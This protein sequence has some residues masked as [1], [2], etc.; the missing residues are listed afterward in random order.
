[1]LKRRRIGA[2]LLTAL[3]TILAPIAGSA[4]APNRH[5]T[6]RV[7]QGQ[8]E[9]DTSKITPAMVDAGRAIF[10]GKGT[11]FACHGMQLEGTQVAPTLKKHA[12]RD[13]K[14]G[15]YAAIF[16]V[17]TH[18]VPGTLMVAFPGGISRAEVLNVAAYVWSVGQGRAK[19]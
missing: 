13:A 9:A 16:S 18:G 11:C 15:E 2:V 3:A 17:A 5:T 8:Q 1:L 19:P 7:V 12:W 14:N 4:G 10:H 6:A